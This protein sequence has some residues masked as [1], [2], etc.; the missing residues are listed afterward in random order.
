MEVKDT[1]FK[2][3]GDVKTSAGK[4]AKGAID[5]SKKMAEK[6]KI[7]HAI[8]KSESELNALYI[9]IGK[10]YEELCA[11][12]GHEEFAPLLAEVERIKTDL[13]LAKASLA[14]MD[15]GAVC[16]GCGAFVQDDQKFCPHC[17]KAHEKPDSSEPPTE[18]E[19]VSSETVV[20]SSEGEEIASV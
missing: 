1:I 4:L 6:A 14:A 9:E 17:G 8:S 3:G 13:S 5:G 10:K 7:K 15:C 2:L 19:L 16:V 11:A 18:E 20:V 12:E